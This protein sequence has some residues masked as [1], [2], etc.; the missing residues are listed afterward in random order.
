MIDYQVEPD[1]NQMQLLYKVKELCSLQ[2][3]EGVTVNV[4]DFVAFNLCMAGLN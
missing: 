1:V 4:K 3:F 2:H